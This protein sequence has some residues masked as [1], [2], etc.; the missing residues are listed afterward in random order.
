MPQSKTRLVPRCWWRARQG[1]GLHRQDRD[2]AAWIVEW[3]TLPQNRVL[4]GRALAI[5]LV[6]RIQ[7]DA[8]AMS[9]DLNAAQGLIHA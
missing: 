3:L 2:H 5:D 8:I 6:P 1:A 9:R 7:P 4:T